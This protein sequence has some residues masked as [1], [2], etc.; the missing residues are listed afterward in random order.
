MIKDE[1]KSMS[2]VVTVLMLNAGGRLEQG[3]AFNT[4]ILW[5]F[6]MDF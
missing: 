3:H 1:R 4:G 5:H 2:L 6:I